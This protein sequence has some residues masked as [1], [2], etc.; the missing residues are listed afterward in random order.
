MTVPWG[1]GPPGLVFVLGTGRCGSTLVH[2]ILARHGD[3]G[4]VSNVDDR[5]GGLSRGGRRNQAI[6]TRVPARFT[7]KGRIRFAPSE[8]YRVLDA[9]VS[10]ILS[11]PYR[12]LNASDVTPWLATRLQSFFVQRAEAQGRSI[13]LHKF[14][15]WPRALLLAQVFPE[16]RFIHVVR[17]GRA[18]VNSW[19]QMPWWRGH[20]GPSRWHFGPLSP[21]ETEIWARHDESLVALAGLAWQRLVDAYT[22]CAET[23]GADRWVDVRYEDIIAAPRLHVNALLAG[24]GLRWDDRFEGAFSRYRFSSSRS[25]AFRADLGDRHVATLSDVAAKGLQRHGYPVS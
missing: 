19:L 6:Y 22:T 25:E 13:F 17:D 10:P 18:V 9:L 4:F 7:Q 14:T 8:G 20:Q 23:L 24:M 16:A 12:D 21:V 3:V 11:E 15:G 2:E 5:L 1:G